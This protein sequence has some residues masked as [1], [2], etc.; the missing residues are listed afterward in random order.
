MRYK[1]MGEMNEVKFE[2]TAENR[3]QMLAIAEYVFLSGPGNWIEDENGYV[4][5]NRLQARQ[6]WLRTAINDLKEALDE[7]G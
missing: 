2:G 6:L 5:E 3:E 4:V 7:R 1:V